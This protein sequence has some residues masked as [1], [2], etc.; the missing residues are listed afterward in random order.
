MKDVRG[1]KSERISQLSSQQSYSILDELAS[2]AIEVKTIKLLIECMDNGCVSSYPLEL[3]NI[4]DREVM[5]KVA[6]KKENIDQHNE[7]YTVL[8]FSDDKDLIKQYRLAPSEETCTDAVAENE[9]NSALTTPAKRSKFENELSM[10]DANEDPSVQLSRST[11]SQDQLPDLNCAPCD[12]GQ[13]DEDD[14][15]EDNVNYGNFY[16]EGMH[17]LTFI[18]IRGQDI[19]KLHVAIVSD[20]KKMLDS[21]NVLAKTFRM[22]RD[23][24]QEDRSSKVRLR[25][26]GKRGTDGRRYNF[27]TVSEVAA[28]VVGDFEPSRSDR[29]IIIESHSGQL[30]RINELNAAYLSLQYPLLFSY[31]KDGYREDIPITTTDDKTPR[32]RRYVSCQEYFAYKIQ[33]IKDEFP[34]ILSSRRLFQQFLVDRYTKIKSFRL[35]YFRFNQK[36]LRAHMYKGLEDALLR[37]EIDPSS[38]GK[39]DNS[40]IKLH[41]RNYFPCMQ[42]GRCTKYFPKKTVQSI[43]IDE[44][45]Y[46][47]YRRRED[48]RTIKKDGIDLDNRQPPVERLAFHLRDEQNVI[49]SD[50]NPIDGVA[51]RPSVRESMFLS[52]FEEN[53]RFPEARELTYAE[54]PLKLLLNVIKGATSYEDL[55]KINNHDHT[56]FRDAWYALGLLDDDK[57]YID[58]VKEASDWGMPS[59]LRQLF[60]MLLLSNSMSQPE[61]V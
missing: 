41:K 35:N 60:A 61:Y 39:R 11:Q 9:V 8:K 54:F 38:Q 50:D 49:F 57:E 30:Q 47:I 42:N 45:G 14:C 59:Y 26:I 4:L 23:R 36:L 17:Y 51:N 58:A 37:R 28:L 44:Y 56:T 3:D 12:E 43:T 20:L 19:N 6:I 46:L 10:V 22:V 21:H 34:T 32:G 24:F 29:D 31:G 15:E 2:G 1:D 27:P 55:E 33:D 5:F 53:K 16:N 48:G 40:G 7:V 52:W 18:Y 13:E 25:L